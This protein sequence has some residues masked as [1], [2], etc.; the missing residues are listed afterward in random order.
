MSNSRV[1]PSQWGTTPPPGPRIHLWKQEAGRGTSKITT[2][3]TQCDRWVLPDI[4]T[5]D[6]DAVT[7]ADCLEN[8]G[9]KKE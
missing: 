3:G 6:M 1:L 4:V 7:C 5:D 2:Y 8:M 9:G